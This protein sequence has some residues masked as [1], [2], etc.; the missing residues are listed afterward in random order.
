MSAIAST[1][2]T[3]QTGISA[4]VPLETVLFNGTSTPILTKHRA[5]DRMGTAASCTARTFPSSLLPLGAA[6]PGGLPVDCIKRRPDRC[7]TKSLA[8]PTSWRMAGFGR[9]HV[10]PRSY[11]FRVSR[12]HL[13]SVGGPWEVMCPDQSS[14]NIVRDIWHIKLDNTNGNRWIMELFPCV[15][16]SGGLWRDPGQRDI[17]GC[18]ARVCQEMDICMRFVLDSSVQLSRAVYRAVNFV[19]LDH[20]L[21]VH[22]LSHLIE[23]PCTL[24]DPAPQRGSQSAAGTLKV[25]GGKD[26]Y[27]RVSQGI[28]SNATNTWLINAHERGVGCEREA[29]M[30]GIHRSMSCLER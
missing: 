2:I 30:E 14:R 18:T 3:S 20:S 5:G 17:L 25:R 7:A 23:T 24:I 9:R 26:V 10:S 6:P 19:G 11:V 28:T 21:A 22:I 27:V 12:D 4:F 13:P 16:R 8:A 15:C 1:E 29:G